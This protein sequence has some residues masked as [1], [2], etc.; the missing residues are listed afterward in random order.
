MA[1][2]PVGLRDNNLILDY[3]VGLLSGSGIERERIT[4]GPMPPIPTWD[5]AY[6]VFLKPRTTGWERWYVWVEGCQKLPTKT[7]NRW[8]ESRDIRVRG[9]TARGDFQDSRVYMQDTL[10]NLIHYMSRTSVKGEFY[11]QD[12]RGKGF[13]YRTPAECQGELVARTGG[14]GLLLP[15]R[16]GL[17]SHSG[18]TVRRNT[19]A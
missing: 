15:R 16:V 13:F 17:P 19:I 4:K 3:M 14:R 11:D 7:E 9:L 6:K 12:P 1:I 2:Y 8:M 10:T 5:E 18:A